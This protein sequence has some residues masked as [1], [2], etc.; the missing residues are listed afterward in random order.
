MTQRIRKANRLIA[1]GNGRNARVIA[2]VDGEFEVPLILD[3]HNVIRPILTAIGSP[4]FALETVAAASHEKKKDESDHCRV[5]VRFW[6]NNPVQLYARSC[7]PIV[8]SN[9]Y[10]ARDGPYEAGAKSRRC[11]LF[12]LALVRKAS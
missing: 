9:L 5:P 1:F 12:M 2:S 4:S 10:I 3:R 7:G 6:L 11:S 8:T